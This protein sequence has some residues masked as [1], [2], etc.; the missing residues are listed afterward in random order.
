M[1]VVREVRKIYG[2]ELTIMLPEDFQEKEVE[3]LVLPF[4]RGSRLKT[5]KKV[6][7]VKADIV[8]AMSEVKMMREGKIPEKSAREMLNEL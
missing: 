3:I 2:R 6:E 8:E 5:G 1:N 4:N 7:E